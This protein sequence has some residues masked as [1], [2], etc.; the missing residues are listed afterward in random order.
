MNKGRKNTHG[1]GSKKIKNQRIKRKEAE[2]VKEE[3]KREN[4]A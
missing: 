3:R 4:M 2:V 1:E